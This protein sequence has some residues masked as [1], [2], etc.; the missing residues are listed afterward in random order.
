MRE[1][2]IGYLPAPLEFKF[3]QVLEAQQTG[4]SLVQDFGGFTQVEGSDFREASS[5]CPRE[6]LV[7]SERERSH[8]PS[9]IPGL[10][11]EQ[12][13]KVVAWRGHKEDTN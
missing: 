12:K 6:E 2:G 10:A 5:K 8:A 4:E 9:C 3:D 7:G 11:H 1:A 13:G